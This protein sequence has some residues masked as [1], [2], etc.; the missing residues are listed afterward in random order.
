MTIWNMIK[1]DVFVGREIECG[2]AQRHLSGLGLAT[3]DELPR[4]VMFHGSGGIGK[5]KL[6]SEM[7]RRLRARH[8]ITTSVIDLKESNNRILLS[9][10]RTIADQV[11]PRSFAEFYIH[12]ENYDRSSDADKG[13][14]NTLAVETFLEVLRRIAQASPVV[15]ILD[16]IESVQGT[17]FLETLLALLPRC[18]GRCGF[19]LAGRKD[20]PFSSEILKL[21]F[22]IS[23]FLAPDIKKMAHRMFAA[24]RLEFSMDSSVFEK[25]M[26]VTKGKPILCALTIDW[27]MENPGQTKYITGLGKD[28]FER[29]IILCLKALEKTEI[30]FIELMAIVVRGLDVLLAAKLSGKSENECARII[31]RLRRFSFVR[32]L[33]AENMIALHDEIVRLV[34][35]YYILNSCELV[36]KTVVT[37][38]EE[39]TNTSGCDNVRDKGLIADLLYYRLKSDKNDGLRY[40]DEQ[41]HTALESFDYDLCALLINELSSSG[42]DSEVRRLGDLCR[43]ELLIAHYKPI[44]AKLILDNLSAE[45]GAEKDSVFSARISE[46]YGNVIVNACT[47]VG[48]DLFEAVEHFKSSH[49]LYEDK[50]ELGRIAKCLMALGKTYVYIGRHEDAEEAFS[51]ALKKS[52]VQGTHKLSARILDEMGEMYRLQQNIEKALVPLKESYRMRTTHGD[53]V[54]LGL[55]YFYLGN[56]YRDLDSFGEADKYYGLAERYLLA[57]DDAFRLC[58]LYCE[59]SWRRRLSEE[60]NEAEALIEKAWELA[61]KHEFGT[62]Y[63]EYYHIKYEISMARGH[64]ETAYAELDKAL[65]SARKY[66]NIYI[67]LD[68]LNHCAQRAYAKKEYESISGF[69]AEMKRYE[70]LGCGIRVFTGRAMMVLGDAHYDNG[71]FDS[72]CECWKEGLTTIA[73]YGNSR[74]NVELFG[75]ILDKRR[76]SI[77]PTLTI[78]GDQARTSFIDHWARH[79]LTETFPQLIEVCTSS[80][81]SK[82]DG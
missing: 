4:I 34:T 45:I 50:K 75:D 3:L 81:E 13:K 78:L 63:S 60:F 11:A 62:E 46:G 21:S 18:G 7:R 76:E 22:K 15:V 67:I 69:I 28:T 37:Y 66:S 38:Y 39:N 2:A 56:T 10:M 32:V 51:L 79:G 6:A 42:I 65:L 55:Y 64:R 61:K 71:E 57:V 54:N 14:Y 72:A 41:F 8:L 48:A 44:E 12:L 26:L 59:M 47:I 53:E 9:L 43:A 19:I 58:E 16:T 35:E 77:R 1:H 30:K 73:L 23:G 25:L 31:E 24:R 80:I 36:L 70:N 40:C 52:K 17:K 33:P 74:T 82:C 20:I 68:C 27:L 29:E 49:A 5:T